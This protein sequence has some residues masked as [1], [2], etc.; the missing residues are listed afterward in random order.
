MVNGVRGSSPGTGS[1]TTISRRSGVTGRSTP[2]M[3]PI[4]ADHG[5]AAQTTVSVRIVPRSVRTALIARA[6]VLDALDRGAAAQRGAG[7][8]GGA[9]VAEHDRL[10]RA[11]PVGR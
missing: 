6:V 3:A 10:G 11:V 5:P 8:A 7:S 9:G 4:A 2:A 1:V